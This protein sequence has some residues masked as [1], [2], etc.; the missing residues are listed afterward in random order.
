MK[1][2]PD[3]VASS[4]WK[5]P[6]AETVMYENLIRIWLAERQPLLFLG[7]PSSGKREAFL[8][9]LQAHNEPFIHLNSTNACELNQV[10]SKACVFDKTPYGVILRPKKIHTCIT[11]F[12]EMTLPSADRY[13]DRL[14]SFIQQVIQEG[15]YYEY[16][17]HSWVR[18]ANIQIVCTTNLPIEAKELGP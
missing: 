11:I 14:N 8:K 16:L 9:V 12:G 18:L 10:L 17:S 7:P 6:T 5:V 15:A 4:N 3:K 2:E 13:A 1:S